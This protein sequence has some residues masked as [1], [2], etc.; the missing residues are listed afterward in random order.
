MVWA[1][2]HFQ[3]SLG[4]ASRNLYIC[5]LPGERL[6]FLLMRAFVLLQLF[7]SAA[8]LAAGR[9]LREVSAKDAGIVLDAQM[10]AGQMEVDSA[11]RASVSAL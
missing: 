4:S 1:P 6:A 11:G 2:H 10:Q 5:H 9:S 7:C 3:V 8:P